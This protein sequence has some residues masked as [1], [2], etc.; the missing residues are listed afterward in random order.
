LTKRQARSARFRRCIPADLRVLAKLRQAQ[1]PCIRFAS[2][3]AVPPQLC[4][5]LSAASNQLPAAQRRL[6]GG[7]SMR[8][9]SVFRVR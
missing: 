4:T 5:L 6:R 1:C 9:G 8:R 3:I 7:S 2:R